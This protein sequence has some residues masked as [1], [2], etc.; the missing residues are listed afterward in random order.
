[1]MLNIYADADPGAK[2]RGAEAVVEAMAGGTVGE[3][4][5]MRTTGTED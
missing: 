1:M 4:I 5:Q 2:R 3:V